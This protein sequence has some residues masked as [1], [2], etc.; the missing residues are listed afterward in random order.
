MDFI[1][2]NIGLSIALI[3]IT[4]ISMNIVKFLL[5]KIGEAKKIST[6]RVYYVT[7]SINFLIVLIALVLFIFIWSVSLDG[8]LVFTSSI[9][10]VI[11]VALFAQW[12]ILSNL[13]SSIVIF[14]SSPA[15]IGDEIKVVDGDNSIEGQILEMELFHIKIK[16][17]DDNLV[18]YPNS[19]FLQ[20]PVIKVV[21]NKG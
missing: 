2:K 16:D 21:T 17:K 1:D 18:V 4:F 7:K 9:F 10:A 15:R 6:K 14:F 8:L 11:G 3:V 13:T 5:V 12:S 20:H 19:L